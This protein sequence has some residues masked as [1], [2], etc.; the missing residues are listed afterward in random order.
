MHCTKI[1]AEF[2]FGGHSPWM[3]TPNTWRWLR[4]WENQRRLSSW[5]YTFSFIIIC[6]PSNNYHYLG[7]IQNLSDDNDDINVAETDDS[8]D[9]KMSTRRD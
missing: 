9:G 7:H 2:K 3:C 6:G 5:A 4:R 1:S 8:K